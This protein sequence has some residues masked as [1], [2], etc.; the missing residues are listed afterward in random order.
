MPKTQQKNTWDFPS[1]VLTDYLQKDKENSFQSLISNVHS[2]GRF[3]QMKRKETAKQANRLLPSPDT[4]FAL[5]QSMRLPLGPPKQKRRQGCCS[6]TA[7][8]YSQVSFLA[9]ETLLL[10]KGSNWQII[11]GIYCASEAFSF[12]LPQS[13]PIF[14]TLDTT[15]T[16]ILNSEPMY[17]FK[18]KITFEN[19]TY[20]IWLYSIHQSASQKTKEKFTGLNLPFL[21]KCSV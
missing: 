17:G 16:Y 9:A 8:N 7:S 1:L 5:P 14:Y 21:L 12:P 18:S 11:L 3:I 13:K 10:G 6:T 19:S 15:Y 2:K 4:H 20:A